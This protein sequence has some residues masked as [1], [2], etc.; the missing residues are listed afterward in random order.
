MKEKLRKKYAPVTLTALLL[1]YMPGAFAKSPTPQRQPSTQKDKAVN[2][3]AHWIV[4]K[5]KKRFLWKAYCYTYKGVAYERT[6]MPCDYH[7]GLCSEQGGKSS[8]TLERQTPCGAG[9]S[10]LIEGKG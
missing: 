9:L 5:R 1:A 8:L 2:R 3:R 10:P 7:R 4:C 6:Y